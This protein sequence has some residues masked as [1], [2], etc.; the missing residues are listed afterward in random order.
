MKYVLT[1]EG[2]PDYRAKVPAHLPAHRALWHIYHGDGRLLL[3]GPFTDEPLGGA[4]AVFSTR[5]A[6]EQ[7]V[8][9]DPFVANGVVARWTIREWHE[10]LVPDP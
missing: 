8:G 10:V 9:E 5:A 6:A 3:I 7:F 2:T 1:Y 4:M